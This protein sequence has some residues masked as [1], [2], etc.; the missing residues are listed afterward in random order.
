MPRLL[1]ADDHPMVRATL[2]RVLRRDRRI[3]LVGVA[4]SGEEAAA[5]ARRL[6]PDV[7]LMDLR[8]PG[9]GG[10]EATREIVAHRPSTRVLIF[11]AHPDPH[12]V[13]R[14]LDAGAVGVVVKGA[15]VG[16]LLDAVHGAAGG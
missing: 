12:G 1:L 10:A 5:A 4:A 2:T 6:E 3:E 8:M 15:S 13:R 7:V 16:E 14:A 11:T 9:L